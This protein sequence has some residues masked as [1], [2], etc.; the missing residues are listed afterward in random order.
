MGPISAFGG[1]K[2]LAVWGHSYEFD[3]DLNASTPRPNDTWNIIENFAA[4]VKG[5][6][7]IWK[8]TNIEVYDYIQA[9][10]GLEITQTYV[11]NN[12]DKIAVN[13]MVNGKK[14]VV[15]PGMTYRP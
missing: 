11:K 8:A 6:N 12:S 15:E 3:K 7:D 4:Q 9:L 13:I 5:R 2:L 1:L 14:A 10:N